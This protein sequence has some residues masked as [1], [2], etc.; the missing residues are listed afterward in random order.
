MNEGKIAAIPGVDSV[1]P[2]M[3]WPK[4]FFASVCLEEVDS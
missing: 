3:A 1:W 4:A 2:D